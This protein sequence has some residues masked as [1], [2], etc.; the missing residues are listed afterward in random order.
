MSTRQRLLSVSHSVLSLQCLG[1]I[2]DSVNVLNWTFGI[3]LSQII[4]NNGK[5]ALTHRSPGWDHS[6]YEVTAT[7]KRRQE[8]F[9][10]NLSVF[11]TPLLSLPYTG[12]SLHVHY[13][14]KRPC[15]T[16]EH[17]EILFE[18]LLFKLLNHSDS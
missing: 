15:S 16:R 5:A 7:I 12:Q 18:G 3:K 11:Q 10:S 13:G 6:P 17:P 4:Q 8:D 9:K 14:K 1:Q 2:G